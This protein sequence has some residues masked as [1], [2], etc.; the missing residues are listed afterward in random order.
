VH[1]CRQAHKRLHLAPLHTNTASVDVPT[2]AFASDE[3]SADEGERTRQ[4][5]AANA[6]LAEAR[7]G[8]GDGGGVVG[9]GISNAAAGGGGGGQAIVAAD[10]PPDQMTVEVSWACVCDC[11]CLP[12]SA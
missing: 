3:A 9:G 10:V 6:H 1:T 11:K 12:S 8:A 4:Q 5:R 2:R 7:L